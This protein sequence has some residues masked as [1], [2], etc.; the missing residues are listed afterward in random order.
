M[1][2]SHSTEKGLPG[3]LASS[4]KFIMKQHIFRLG[5]LFCGPGGFG[6]A[7]DLASGK[8]AGTHFGVKHV[9]ANDI[10][11]DSCETYLKNHSANGPRVLCKDIRKV[12]FQRDLPESIDALTFGFPCNDFSIVGERSGLSGR[13]GPLYTHG[14]MAVAH[15]RPQWFIAENVGGIHNAN[16][17][18]AL[19]TI[20]EDLARLRPRYNITPHYYRFE[21]YGVPQTRHRIMIVGIRADL[22]LTFRVPKE[23]HKG[24]PITAKQ[25]LSNIPASALNQELTRQSATVV[26]RLSHIRPGQNAW[27][28]KIPPHLRL[29]VKGARLSQIY[30]RLHPNKPAYTVTGSGGG[31]TH[32]Y[33]YS[34]PRALTNRERAR[35][36]TFED[37]YV[38]CG[39]INSV[40]RQIGMAIPPRGVGKVIEAIFQTFAGISYPTIDGPGPRDYSEHEFV[41][42]EPIAS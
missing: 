20:F 3:C 32:V 29:N 14:L 35:L 12:N 18:R 36:Q 21:D 42:S 28:A 7:A 11:P 40:R 9:W 19:R 38:F 26:A 37:S 15:Y 13:Y 8:F 16:D 23:T 24:C 25:A 33:H 27:D 34:E 4:P 31:G 2:M 17:G 39:P 30:K 22:G 41:S 10:H 6:H 1:G 5:E